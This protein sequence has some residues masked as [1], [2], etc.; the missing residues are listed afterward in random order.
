VFGGGDGRQR[1]D[2]N[3]FSTLRGFIE[4]HGSSRFEPT[5]STGEKG[6]SN[7]AGFFKTIDS[8]E[9]AKIGG[10][11]A[12]G[13]EFWILPEAF[14]TQVFAGMDHRHA[15]RVLRDA[16]VLVPGE[17]EHMAQCQRIPAIGKKT[18][19]YVIGPKLWEVET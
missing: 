14:R 12:D 5:T 18:R 8:K 6:V 15:L 16:G 13:R 9:P 17:G 10:T 3:V 19:V 4:A 7:R 2:R 11:K 1:E